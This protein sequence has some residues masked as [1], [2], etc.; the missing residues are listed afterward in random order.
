[1]NLG[2]QSPCK[3]CNNMNCRKYKDCK[4]WRMWFSNE[5]FRVRMMFM[6]EKDA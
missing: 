3:S 2:L 5:W 1:M 4:A 6:E